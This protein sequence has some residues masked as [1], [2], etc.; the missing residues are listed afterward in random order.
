MWGFHSN[1]SGKRKLQERV[2]RLVEND[3]KSLIEKFNM[4]NLKQLC[5]LCGVKTSGKREDVLKRLQESD[6]ASMYINKSAF[7][8]LKELI[9]LKHPL[10]SKPVNARKKT[11]LH[12]LKEHESMFFFINGFL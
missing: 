8:L 4:E 11:V 12:A 5:K 6:I 2:N 1:G 7:D 3:K 10:K 9:E